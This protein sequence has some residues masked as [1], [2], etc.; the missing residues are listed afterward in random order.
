MEWRVKNDFTGR[1]YELTPGY[2]ERGLRTIRFADAA[3]GCAT[4]TY[5]CQLS[6]EERH[7]MARRILAALTW[8]SNLTLEQ[9]EH[10]AK[11]PVERITQ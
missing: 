11:T 2:D 8:T 5:S 1:K 4:T 3:C 9:L 6:A 7:L 10:L